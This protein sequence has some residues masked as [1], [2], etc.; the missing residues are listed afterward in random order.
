MITINTLRY[1]KE[2]SQIDV[3]VSVPVGDKITQVLFWHYNTFDTPEEAISLDTLLLG[4]SNVETF[5]I[6]LA[7]VSITDFTGLYF[8]QFISDNETDNPAKVGVVG[9][10]SK[11]YNCLINKVLSI[12]ISDCNIEEETICKGLID[13]CGNNIYYLN[14]LL[15]NINRALHYGFFIEAAAAFGKLKELIID[16]SNCEENNEDMDIY[17]ENN[18]VKPCM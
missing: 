14:A 13:E 16:C 10:L 3:D 12:D 5:S 2:N 7:T 9:N 15:N 6:P 11:Y 4:T 1:N 17:T 8:I 18:E